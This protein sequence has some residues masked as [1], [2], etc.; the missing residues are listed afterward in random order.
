MLVPTSFSSDWCSMNTKRT[1]ALIIGVVLLLTGVGV[2]TYYT[3]FRDPEPSVEAP[4]PTVE[5]SKDATENKEV[6]VV[7][8]PKFA[9]NAPASK[10]KGATVTVDGD[11]FVYGGKKIDVGVKKVREPLEPCV[12]KEP[13]DYCLAGTTKKANVFFFADPMNSVAFRNVEEFNRTEDGDYE[14]SLEGRDARLK[15]NEDG[16]GF[17]ILSTVDKE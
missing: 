5:P 15:M 8:S 1:V 13:S 11:K 3:L 16:T 4:M 17:L 9:K 6:P 12:T 14:F 7:T 2:G 10:H